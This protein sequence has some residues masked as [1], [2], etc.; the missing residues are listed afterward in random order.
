MGGGEG[1][2]VSANKYS[3]AHGAQMNGFEDLT[4]YLYYYVDFLLKL[5]PCQ[6]NT[7]IHSHPNLPRP[8]LRAGCLLRQYEQYCICYVKYNVLKKAKCAF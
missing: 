6:I 4:P 5:A 3:C 8:Q 7:Q 1:Y 2:G